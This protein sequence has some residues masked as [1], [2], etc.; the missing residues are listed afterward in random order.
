MDRNVIT[1]DTVLSPLYDAAKYNWG[2]EWSVPTKA[3]FDELL[4]NCEISYFSGDIDFAKFI[5]PNGNELIIPNAGHITEP[6]IYRAGRYWSSSPCEDGNSFMLYI[7]NKHFYGE[8]STA[9][10]HIQRG[11][12]TRIRPVMKPNKK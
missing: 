5:G 7:W 9:M 3:D 10:Q 6:S 4:E 1:K 2:D 12:L 8:V 11:L